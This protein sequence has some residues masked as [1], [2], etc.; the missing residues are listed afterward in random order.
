MEGTASVYSE[1]VAGRYIKVDINRAQAARFNLNIAGVQVVATAIGGMDVT[2][3]IEGQERYPVS[4]RY[5][6]DLRDSPEALKALPIV[7]EQGLNITLGDVA[8][9]YIENGPPGIKSENA[10]INGWTFIDLDGAMLATTSITPSKYWLSS[11]SYQ[12]GTQLLGRPVR[13]H[14]AGQ[15]QAQLRSATRSWYH[16]RAVIHEL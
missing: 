7:T 8:S 2:Q 1:R 9:V 5:P 4:L 12:Q 3:T 16:H 11:W 13:I 14:G 15:S 6:Q 10:R